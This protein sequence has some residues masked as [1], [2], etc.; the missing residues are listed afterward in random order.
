MKNE[1]YNYKREVELLKTKL[2]EV[3]LE[4]EKDIENLKQR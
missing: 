1:I 4:N 3:K 2:E